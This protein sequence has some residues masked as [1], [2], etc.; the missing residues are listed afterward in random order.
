MAVTSEIILR[1]PLSQIL[2]Y[3][4][5]YPNKIIFQRLFLK[6][7]L[8]TLSWQTA[9]K[10]PELGAIYSAVSWREEEGNELC[11]ALVLPRRLLLLPLLRTVAVKAP[12]RHVGERWSFVLAASICDTAAAGEEAANMRAAL[13]AQCC[14]NIIRAEG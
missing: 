6:D 2:H 11:F 8:A 3:F 14:A 5:N 4:L 10:P 12:Q 1:R 9:A 13:L 7:Y